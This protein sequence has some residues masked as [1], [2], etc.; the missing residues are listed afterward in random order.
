[1][2]SG[3]GHSWA[4]KLSQRASAGGCAL[5]GRGR[6]HH[7]SRPRQFAAEVGNDTHAAPLHRRP[8][9]AGS[10]RAARGTHF[11]WI[12][13]VS[14]HRS[15][16]KWPRSV[17]T[18][19]LDVDSRHLHPIERGHLC[20]ARRVDPR[21][22]ALHVQSAKTAKSLSTECHARA[23]TPARRSADLMPTRGRRLPASR[24]SKDL[25]PLP[26][27]QEETAGLGLWTGGGSF[28]QEETVGLGLWTGGGSFRQEEKT[29]PGLGSCGGSPPPI[30][31]QGGLDY[32]RRTI[33]R[34]IS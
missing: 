9:P 14:G 7:A 6:A 15:R 8:R 22:V 31:G 4:L 26:R 13:R 28:R 34:T 10:V 23:L 30:G 18:S 5:L 33:G 12:S 27:R 1:V 17:L 19:V 24:R 3:A 32:A 16:E 2:A 20:Q 25:M 29:R 11:L 21:E